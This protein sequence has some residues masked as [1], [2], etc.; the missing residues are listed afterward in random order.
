VYWFISKNWCGLVIALGVGLLGLLVDVSATA[1][2]V[3]WLAAMMEILGLV[4]KVFA[5][6]LLALSLLHL[7]M[8]AYAKRRFPPPGELV[9]VGGYRMHILAEGE[10]EIPVVWIPGS[11]DQGM[12]FHHLHKVIKQE[13][14]SILYDRAGSGW[15]DVG[16]F[17]RR[18]CLEVDELYRL[19]EAS[20]ETGPFVLVAHSLGGFAAKSFAATYPEKVAGLV[21]LDSACADA[22]V[23]ASRLKENKVPGI[24][25]AIWAATAFGLAWFIV[26]RMKKQGAEWLSVYD[27]ESIKDQVLLGN[28]Q[29]KLTVGFAGALK[30][31][32]DFPF[33]LVKVPDALGDMPVFAMIP[34]APKAEQLEELRQ[35]LP[36]WSQGELDNFLDL[37]IDSQHQNA[38]LSSR[39]ELHYA[40]TGATHNFPFEM[41]EVV[42]EEVRNMLSLV[43]SEAS[44]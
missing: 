43:A 32:F 2:A 21:L 25:F 26:A 24:S 42:F 16:P 38:S 34:P 19:L 29:P 39:G 8:L 12:A 11:H 40:P 22:S 31:V 5:A 20:G 41:P 4:L 13:T 23:Y 30:A 14:R 15:S 18:V 33:D 37:R 3:G 1:M 6:I 7:L 44:G 17:P 35:F 10:G 27:E 9:D 28:C 36:H